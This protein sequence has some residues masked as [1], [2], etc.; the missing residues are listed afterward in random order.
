MNYEVTN[1]MTYFVKIETDISNK[2]LYNLSKLDYE[3][4]YRPNFQQDT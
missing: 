2:E 3:I 1:S 4:V